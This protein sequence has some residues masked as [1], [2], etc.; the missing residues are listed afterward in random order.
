M[1]GWRARIGLLIDSLNTVC[2]PD[3]H[4]MRPEGVSIH[5]SRMYIEKGTDIESLIEMHKQIE[6]A[7]REV[8]TAKVN[9]IC[10]G[11]TTGSLVKGPGSD[12]E[13]I[14]RIER[15]TGIPS[16]TTSTA[17]VAALREMGIKRLSVATPY[18]DD[19]N[20]RVKVF[21]EAEGLEVMKLK[22]LTISEPTGIGRLNPNV[23]YRLAREIDVE[24][25]EGVFISC[26]DF[27]AIDVIE[28]LEMDLRKPVVSSNQASMWQVLKMLS[29]REPLHGFG[30]LLESL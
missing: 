15:E 12:R 6:R 18:P 23:A 16:T 27:R 26:T 9:V 24:E 8:A 14:E 7:A 29:I 22:G 28:M 21:L 25:A 1:Y 4:R 13:I 2:E 3:F 19:L 10:F 20:E 17:V 5:A 11:D 30:T